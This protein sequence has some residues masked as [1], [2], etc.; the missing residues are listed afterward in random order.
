MGAVALFAAGGKLIGKKDLGSMACTYGNIY[1]AQVAMGYNDA[2]TVRAFVEAESYDGPSLIIAYS[3]CIN[4]GIDMTKGYDQQKAGRGDAAAWFLWRFDP[5]LAAPGKNPW[6]IDM[7]EPSRPVDRLR[8]QREPLQHAQEV[9]PE[10]GRHHHGSG[11]EPR[12]DALGDPQAAGGHHLFFGFTVRD[13]R[14]SRGD[15]GCGRR[16][17]GHQDRR[18]HAGGGPLLE[19]PR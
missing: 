19:G 15:H 13:R 1:V 2:Q 7:K 17:H 9:P 11:A 4:Q 12:L 18:E 14:A 8:L 16:G 5:R 3:H 10:D 6:Q